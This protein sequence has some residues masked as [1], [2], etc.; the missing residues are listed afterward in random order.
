MKK[1]RIAGIL[2][3]L[4]IPFIILLVPYG[5]EASAPN[6]LFDIQSHSLAVQIDPS[7]HLIK[8][9]DRMEI[10]LRNESAQ[11]LSLLLH[12]KLRIVRIANLKTR[13]SLRWVETSF[14]PFSK[15]VDISLKKSEPSLSLSISYEGE[16]YDPIA[17]EKA[18][19]FVRGDETSGLIGPEGVYLSS[20]SQWYPDRPDSVAS[21]KVEATIPE[22]FRIVTQGELLSERLTG[23]VWRTKW[24]YELPA[25]SLTL[26]GGRYSVKTRETGGIKV[27]TYFFL[28]DDRFSNVFLDAAEQYLKTY[29]N[30]LGSYPYK[31]F[32]IVQNF[33][34]SGYGFPT[35]TLL[36]PEAIRQGK[37]FLR[38][39]ALDHEIVHS[40]WG[41]YVAGKPGTG[42][43]VEALTTYCANYYYKELK[44]GE[45]SARKHRQDVLQKYA[46]QVPSSRDY[47]LRR[48]EGKRDEVDGQIGYGKGSMVFHMLREVVGKDLFFGT[49]RKFSREYGGKQAGWGDIV[50]V[51]EEA[52]GKRLDWFFSE[53]LD[54]PG[55]PRLKLENV[56]YE[57]TPKG[58]LVSAEVLQEGE[59]YEFPIWV[60]VDDGIE[61]KGLPVNVSK[62]RNPFSI[63]VRRIPLTLTVDPN[64]NIFR[65]LYPEEILPGLNA[66]LEE[67]EKIFILPK[68]G[69]EESKKIYAELARMAQMSKG[70]EILPEEKLSEKE[71]LNSSLMLLGDSWKNPIFSKLISR[72]P[73]PIRLKDGKFILDGEPVGGEDE[74]FLLTCPHPLRAGKWVTIYFGTS[75]L[76]LSRARF[77]F[78]YGWDSYI[79]F[80]K[81][82]PA[83]RGNLPPSRSFTTYEFLSK[84]Y[85][86]N[87]QSRGLQDHVK[88]LA[89]PEMAGRFPGT[90]GYHKAQTYL[91]EQLEAM[92]VTPV[93][94]PFTIT[95]RDIEVAKLI[96]KRPDKEEEVKAI[97]L[98]F[99]REGEWEGPLVWVRKDNIEDAPILSGKGVIL[100]DLD[101]P[102]DLSFKTIL[103]KIRILQSMGASAILI[104]MKEDGLDLLTPYITYPSYVPPTL[105]ERLKYREKEGYYINPVIEASKVRARAEEPDFSIHIP[106]LIIPYPQ[107]EL[108]WLKGASDQE[109]NFGE[110]V[111]QFREIHLSDSNIGG[112]IVGND[113][114][115]KNDFLVLGAHYDHLGKDE[116]SGIFYSGADDNGSG[117][118]ALLEIGRSLAEKKRELK[119]SL[120]LIFFGGEEWGLAGS[121]YYV[122]NPFIPLTQI[123][124]M[125]S[126]DSMGGVTDGNEVFIIGSSFHS[127]LA[128]RS[129]RFLSW[130]GIKEGQDI[131]RY[132]FAFG[133]DHYPFHQ[134]GVPALDY[135]ASDYKR[136]HT[137]H[138]DLE[139][140]DFEK[141]TAIAQLVYLTAYEF[142]T[143]P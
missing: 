104:L 84:T 91:M 66:L 99:S 115:K 57:V 106:I 15:R 63:E 120:F 24:S 100:L 53:W 8:A 62:E 108:E 2:S 29:S 21:F 125:L 14:S 45:E 31:K 140:V 114:E 80:E 128:Q 72:L 40:W 71:I 111:F 35:F 113:P 75:S 141:L 1:T 70:G 60:E 51:F 18:L 49:L 34:S 10:R 123:K 107:G 7:K 16:I 122:Q 139:A 110:L 142:L 97:P 23:G 103:E 69:D 74:S 50:K 26:V 89:S 55:G 135:F 82:R 17:K 136:I 138:D 58:Y 129:R 36:A 12:P 78:F 105:E 11:T 59:T 119:R 39:G 87:I 143:E 65:R 94:Q 47:P 95:V 54:R 37:E 92:G 96:L 67:H 117:V 13:R 64:G 46:I 44:I 56:R 93:I 102:K 28:E 33:F 126:L 22:P 85:L 127:S 41:H 73:G 42:N 9:Q 77:I 61:K 112:V 27:R 98:S 137:A 48:F 68:I 130:L 30:L 134:M 4:F 133:S 118:A 52:S 86:D 79:L 81:G 43:W 121:R 131:D 25:E 19:Q 109:D 101:S 83:K 116:K 90:P 132:A 38:P 124:A 76:G 20:G 3:F 88:Y 6:F 5:G 32:D